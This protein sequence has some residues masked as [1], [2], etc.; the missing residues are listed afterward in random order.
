MKKDGKAASALKRLIILFLAVPVT[1][2][3]R[4]QVLP[5]AGDKLSE[6]ALSGLAVLLCYGPALLSETWKPSK[7]ILCS[8]AAPLLRLLGLLGLV[9]LLYI[10]RPQLLP[11]ALLLYSLWIATFLV[12]QVAGRVIIRK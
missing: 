5:P 12:F 11:E 4:E 9:V 6:A 7:A 8:L 10:I 2:A 1:L 3:L